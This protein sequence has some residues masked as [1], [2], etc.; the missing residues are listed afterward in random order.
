MSKEKLQID[1]GIVGLL[2]G[3]ACLIG[4]VFE[5]VWIISTARN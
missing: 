1:S 3:M 5:I 4:A 2:L